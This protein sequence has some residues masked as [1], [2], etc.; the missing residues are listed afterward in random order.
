MYYTFYSSQNNPRLKL[1]SNHKSY[2]TQK[3]ITSMQFLLLNILVV[4]MSYFYL[5][6]FYWFPNGL[7]RAHNPQSQIASVAMF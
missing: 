3:K 1:Q 2:D 5:S 6:V 4:N 7:A